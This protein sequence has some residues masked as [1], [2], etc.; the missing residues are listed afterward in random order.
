[1]LGGV[2]NLFLQGKETR[3]LLPYS[4][5]LKCP[6]FFPLMDFFG[7]LYLSFPSVSK[8]HPLKVFLASGT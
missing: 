2:K 6:C 8:L 5:H 1:M 4:S 7:S 3:Y